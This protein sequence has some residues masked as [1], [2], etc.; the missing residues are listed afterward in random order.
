MSPRPRPD[1]ADRLPSRAGQ[2][3]RGL[4]D[5]PVKWE[6][7]VNLLVLAQVTNLARRYGRDDLSSPAFV[8]T[9]NE[10]TDPPNRGTAWIILKADLPGVYNAIR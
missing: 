6:E 10:K 5:L 7:L 3:G 1:R 4:G 9:P 2:C 8:V